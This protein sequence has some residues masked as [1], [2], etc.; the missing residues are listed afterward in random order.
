MNIV[1]VLIDIKGL[2]RDEYGRPY[3]DDTVK[4]PVIRLF[5]AMSSEENKGLK[6]C[7]DACEAAFGNKMSTGEYVFTCDDAAVG[8]LYKFLRDGEHIECK[9]DRQAG[10]RVISIESTR[11]GVVIQ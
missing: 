6:H 7:K 2:E 1:T 11:R 4:V 5:R 8:R 3:G 9:D 10:Y